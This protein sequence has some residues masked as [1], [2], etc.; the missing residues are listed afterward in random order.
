MRLKKETLVFKKS[1]GVYLLNYLDLYVYRQFRKPVVLFGIGE[2]GIYNLI[3]RVIIDLLDLV[4]FTYLG[5]FNEK[6]N[7]RICVCQ[8]HGNRKRQA[9]HFLWYSAL[10]QPSHVQTSKREW[11]TFGTSLFFCLN[12]CTIKKEELEG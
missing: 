4:I 6:K 8:I 12:Y 9:G 11:S 3:Q 10:I 1:N 7:V 5:H 2:E